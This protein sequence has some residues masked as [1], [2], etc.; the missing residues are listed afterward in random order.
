MQP[1]KINTYGSKH[2][3]HHNPKNNN[4]ICT[5]TY[6]NQTIRGIAKCDPEDDFVLE[7]GQYLAY[8]R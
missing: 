6:K 3:F 1:E 8:L 4:V 2:H 7:N 5:T